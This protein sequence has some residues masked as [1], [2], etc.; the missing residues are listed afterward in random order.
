MLII[1]GGGRC[2]WDDY[3]M[4]RHHKHDIMAV[5][6]VGMHIPSPLAHWY[7]NDAAMIPKWVSCRRYAGVGKLHTNNGAGV[8]VPSGIR[9]W[10]FVGGNSV[11]NAVEVGLAL[12][13]ADI[14]VCGAPLDNS[15]W[16]FS[17]IW[18][19]SH[20]NN[21]NELDEWRRRVVKFSGRVKSMS[22][23]TK[24]ILDGTINN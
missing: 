20:Y 8:G 16:Y 12:G 1:L 23:N 18:E 17:P 19:E 24:R 7:S 15:G 5:N 21:E 13:Y 4:V 6:D 11:I 2:V 10:D 14:V 22:G 9:M 3:D